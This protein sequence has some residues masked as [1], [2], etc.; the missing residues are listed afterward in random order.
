[1]CTDK[2]LMKNSTAGVSYSL[3]VI[4]LHISLLVTCFFFIKKIWLMQV[5]HTDQSDKGLIT[6]LLYS[7]LVLTRKKLTKFTKV[8]Q[9]TEKNPIN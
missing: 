1:M 2:I 5:N 3:T 8:Q 9:V 4:H 6:V 7:S